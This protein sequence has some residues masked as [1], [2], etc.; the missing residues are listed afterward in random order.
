MNDVNWQ[1]KYK[2]WIDKVRLFLTQTAQAYLLDIP[3]LPET[4]TPQITPLSR[5]A[6]EIKEI[7]QDE[8][9]N[10][11]EGDVDLL[12]V[13]QV[14]QFL[15]KLS[16]LYLASNQPSSLH[17]HLDLSSQARTLAKEAKR[18]QEHPSQPKSTHGSPGI[19]PSSDLDKHDSLPPL[20]RDDMSI[21]DLQKKIKIQWANSSNP[22]AP[23][24]QQLIVLLDVAQGLYRNLV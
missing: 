16:D 18:I 7:Y 14:H 19:T 11:P 23:E 8:S 5:K 20:S 24:W 17:N 3:R 15:Q 4:L 22:N 13:D 6:K 9:G 10:L 12:W 2:D 21:E 1:S